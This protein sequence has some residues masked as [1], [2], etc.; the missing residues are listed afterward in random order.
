[1]IFPHVVQRCSPAAVVPVELVAV[2][3]EFNLA[4]DV[5]TSTGLMPRVSPS[6][7]KPREV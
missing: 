2:K 4:R 1:M 6:S 3:F 5:V 7:D